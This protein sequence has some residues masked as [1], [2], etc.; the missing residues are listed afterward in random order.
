MMN[1]MIFYLAWEEEH[2]LDELLDYFPQLI[3][4]VPT[5]STLERIETELQ[6]GQ[7]DRT[8][9]VINVENQPDTIEIIL[10][11]IASSTQLQS[12]P[13]YL[14]GVTEEN[15]EKWQ[16]ICPQAKMIVIKGFLVE[17]NFEQVCRQIES[18]LGGI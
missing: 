13:I 6:E 1:N 18:D 17:F 7:I 3:A 12:I 10:Q 15:Q 4:M 5:V 16:S 8:V 2:W 11:A 14:V 9:L